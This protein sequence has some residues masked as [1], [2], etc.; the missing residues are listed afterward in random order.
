MD[1][2][3]QSNIAFLDQ[4]TILLR[5][6]HTQTLEFAH[7]VLVEDHSESLVRFIEH[8]QE[9]LELRVLCAHHILIALGVLLQ[10]HFD[11]SDQVLPGEEI[12]IV[13]SMLYGS[14][15]VEVDVL[16]DHG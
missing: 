9:N 7:Q 4:I 1:V 15:H 10:T 12:P 5:L 6:H 11:V 16:F 2:L 14:V 8:F 3:L 13:G